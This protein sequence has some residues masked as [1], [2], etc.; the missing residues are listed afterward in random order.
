MAGYPEDAS[1]GGCARQPAE[2]QGNR[3]VTAASRVRRSVHQGNLVGT[4]ASTLQAHS[5]PVFVDE[6]PVKQRQTEEPVGRWFVAGGFGR[7]ES[8]RATVRQVGWQFVGQDIPRLAK[9]GSSWCPGA[10]GDVVIGTVMMP[11][12]RPVLIPSCSPSPL[13]SN[14]RSPLALR[15][16]TGEA[17]LVRPGGGPVPRTEPPPTRTDRP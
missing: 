5:V 15:P 2:R 13:R 4:R 14:P 16:S 17:A 12:V 9:P 11:A 10:A 6:S 7:S 8:A 1:N 3:A